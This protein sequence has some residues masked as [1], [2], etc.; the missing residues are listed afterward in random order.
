MVR[1]TQ[2]PRPQ[3]MRGVQQ[4]AAAVPCL[5]GNQAHRL[6]LPLMRN[7]HRVNLEISET[8]FSPLIRG[9]LRQQEA[10]LG[11]DHQCL[12]AYRRAN[13]CRSDPPSRQPPGT[14]AMARGA[15]HP[16]SPAPAAARPGDTGHGCTMPVPTAA[17][18]AARWCS[19]PG[20]GEPSPSTG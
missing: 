6:E 17:S 13:A 8:L 19:A 2:L 12:L 16:K 10:A 5:F 1:T 9:G 4:G 7:L 14:C 11:G 3:W 15:A 20:A 18:C